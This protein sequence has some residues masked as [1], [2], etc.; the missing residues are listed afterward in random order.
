MTDLL[1]FK[2]VEKPLTIKNLTQ[3]TAEISI[4]GIID[5]SSFWEDSI[6]AKQVFDA[7]KALPSTVNTLNIRL[8]S[9]GG[10]VFA[11][12][13]IYNFLKNLK[14]K[15]VVFVDGMA[16]SIA[17]VIALAGNERHIGTGAMFMIHKPMTGLWGNSLDFIDVIDRLDQVE[18]QIISIYLK[19]TNLGR[20]ELKTLIA[21]TTY[22][23]AGQ[24]IDHGFATE[25]MD[26]DSDVDMAACLKNAYW[27][28]DRETIIRNKNKSSET[29]GKAIQDIKDFTSSYNM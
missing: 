8:N 6:S 22:F 10:S 24:S 15:V 16:A 1:S 7:V 20:T 5:D 13:S 25:I 18:D 26:D 23:D 11:G 14:M 29:I 9:P 17:S 19:N 21:N 27:I 2:K 12:I 3:T 28:A 4:Y